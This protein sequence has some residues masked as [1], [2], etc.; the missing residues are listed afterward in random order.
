MRSGPVTGAVLAGGRG[1]RMKGEDK[2]LISFGPEPLIARVL[3]SLQPQVDA[4]MVVANRNRDDYL[5]YCPRVLADA[6]GVFDGPLAG[7][8][9]ALR[10]ADTPWLVVVPCDAPGCPADM[11]EQPARRGRSI[12]CSRRRGRRGGPDSAPVRAAVA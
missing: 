12:G 5:A 2:G 10:G 4:V 6:V 7:I 9:T 11:V 8:L 1:R 3:A